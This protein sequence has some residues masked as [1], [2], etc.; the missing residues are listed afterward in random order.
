MNYFL[1]NDKFPNLFKYKVEIGYL[2]KK[3]NSC[4]SRLIIYGFNEL[5]L[6]IYL[7]FKDRVVAVVDRAKQG[8]SIDGV[9]IESTDSICSC[10]LDNIFIIAAIHPHSIKE[11]KN[12]IGSRCGEQARIFSI[13]DYYFDEAGGLSRYCPVCETHS[14]HFKP[15]GYNQRED[16]QCP[17]CDS[18]E[19]HRASWLV[20]RNRLSS[21][22]NKKL[23]HIAPEIVFKEPLKNPQN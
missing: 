3:L 9:S 14:N 5:G 4:N 2:V 17:A 7:A 19:R 16:A 15:F 23:L 11:I 13:N 8:K 6:F 12:D 22:E 20:I 1:D 21:V 10:Y 18:L